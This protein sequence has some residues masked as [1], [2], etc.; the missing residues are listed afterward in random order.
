MREL[1][2]LLSAVARMARY[3]MCPAQTDDRVQR[4]DCQ[5]Q[6]R[7]VLN[8]VLIRHTE[9]IPVREVFHLGRREE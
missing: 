9:V 5:R 3:T 2:R 6:I 8:R 4:D 1:S 7:L